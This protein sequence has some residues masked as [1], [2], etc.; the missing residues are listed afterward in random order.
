MLEVQHDAKLHR[1]KYNKRRH[2]PGVKTSGT[3]QKQQAAH[4]LQTLPGSFRQPLAHDSKRAK[5]MDR[6]IATFIAVDIR[7]FSIVDNDT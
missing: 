6:A 4:M 5:E 2:H 1:G 7:P 3:R